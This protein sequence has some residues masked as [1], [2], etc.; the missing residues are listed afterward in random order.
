MSL[1]GSGCGCPAFI[2]A[3][4][5]V[6]SGFLLWDRLR[7]RVTYY[8]NESKSLVIQA[9][10]NAIDAPGYNQIKCD[11]LLRRVD[12]WFDLLR[13]SCVFLIELAVIGGLITLF[14]GYE[15]EWELLC[16]GPVSLYITASWIYY[17]FFK[18]KANRLVRSVDIKEIPTNLSSTGENSRTD[19]EEHCDLQAQLVALQKS[20]MEKTKSNA[21]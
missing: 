12:R 6:N 1:E 8:E 9:C 15:S 20:L 18:F 11:K 2:L 16:L 4:L 17:L 5:I 13:R 3:V 10:A 19:G 7:A 14:L 21:N